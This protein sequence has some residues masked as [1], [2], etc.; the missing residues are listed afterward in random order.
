MLYFTRRMLTP[1]AGKGGRMVTGYDCT[2]NRTDWLFL[3]VEHLFF[4]FF[5]LIGECGYVVDIRR[6]NGLRLYRWSKCR[7][8]PE[9]TAAAVRRFFPVIRLV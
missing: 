2:I 6:K 9:C 4:F 8:K 3:L 1:V 5:S 7:E